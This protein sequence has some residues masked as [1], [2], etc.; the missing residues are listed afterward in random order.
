M[1]AYESVQI[2]GMALPTASTTSL[3]RT[4]SESEELSVSTLLFVELTT[5]L[6]VISV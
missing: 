4:V 1:Q 3:N 6:V 2:I 5:I